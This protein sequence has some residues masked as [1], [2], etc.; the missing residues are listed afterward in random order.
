MSSAD[1]TGVGDR[2]QMFFPN[3]WTSQS[4]DS[5]TVTIPKKKMH[6]SQKQLPPQNNSC[7]VA[8]LYQSLSCV[9]LF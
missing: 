8:V 9:A 2:N 5:F 4:Q 1:Q 3:C 6:L 7:L